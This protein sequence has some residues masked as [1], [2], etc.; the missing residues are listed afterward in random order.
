M[1][2]VPDRAGWVV[3]AV[4]AAILIVLF[5]YL[6]TFRHENG[7]ICVGA[8]P[9]SGTCQSF[10]HP[11]PPLGPGGEAVTDTY[12]F[13]H[14]ALAGDGSI[15][16]R[17]GSLSGRLQSGNGNAVSVGELG[18][19]PGPVQ[20]WAKAGLIITTTTTPPGSPYAALMLTG[21]HGVRMQYDYTHDTAGP[22]ASR[23]SPRFLR[24]TRSGS[25]L[26]GY[27]SA[28][29]SIWTKVG[30]AHLAGLP[31]IVQAGLFVTSPQTAPAP[32]AL[33]PGSTSE[34]TGA[35]ATFDLLGLQGGWSSGG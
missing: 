28:D 17:V 13:V 10:A 8:N 24:L 34:A 32:A 30:S 2:E 31:H 15:A 3:T 29:G 22:A 20:P 33:V 18:G 35:T 21:A 25:T 9:A 7:G 14:R 16:V 27:Q 12:Y 11:N 19:A 6:G 1:G 4:A 5:A 26:T 23:H